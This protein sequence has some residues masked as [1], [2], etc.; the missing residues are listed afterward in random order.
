MIKIEAHFHKNVEMLFIAEGELSLAVNGK[1]MTLHAGEGVFIRPYEVHA[2]GRE[3]VKAWTI[4]LSDSYLDDYRETYCKGGEDYFPSKYLCDAKA[5]REI[6][7][8]LRQ[9][10]DRGKFSCMEIRGWINVVLSRIASYYPP[11]RYDREKSDTFVV[12]A[13]SYIEEHFKEDI[14]LDALASEIGYTRNYCSA[15]FKRYVGETFN[16]YLNAVRARAALALIKEGKT[17]DYS[18]DEAGFTTPRHLLPRLP[19]ARKGIKFLF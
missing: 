15:L 2:F 3:K 18:I 9:W 10:L 11:E 8:L 17:V 13:L 5:N 1:K 6:T 14:D 19:Q 16:D 4:V 12:K 7:A